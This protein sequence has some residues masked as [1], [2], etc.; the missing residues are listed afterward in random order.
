[1]LGCALLLPT[2]QGA[3]FLIERPRLH[4]ARSVLSQVARDWKPGDVV[5][6]DRF[7]AMPFLYYQRFGRVEG[8]DRV[9]VSRSELALSEAAELSE[10]ITRWKGRPR[11]WFLLDTALP[12]PTN[13]SR[14]V[15]KLLLDQNGQELES[16]S[17]RRYSAHLYKLDDEG[18]LAG[19]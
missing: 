12:D 13:P 1:M 11:V 14:A 19:R 2:I 15:L 9:S 10:E 7:S 5:V 4:D 17:C 6:V 3:Q 18:R 16:A 8:L